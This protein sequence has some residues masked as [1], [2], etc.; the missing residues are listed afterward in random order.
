VSSVARQHRC[1]FL[2]VLFVALCASSL[3]GCSDLAGRVPTAPPPDTA[4][5]LAAPE[6]GGRLVYG[7]EVDPTGLDPTRNSWDHAGIQVAN[8]LYDPLAAYDAGGRTRPYL[9]ES[10]APNPS[11]TSWVLTLRPGVTFENGEP[12]DADALL[13]F[14][15]ALRT[16]TVVGP[17][18]QLLSGARKVDGRTIQLST[19]RP[20]ASLPAL[21]AGQGGYLVSTRTVVDLGEHSYPMGTGPFL[22]RRWETGKR[23][24]LVRNPRYWRAGLPYLDAVDFVV[25]DDGTARLDKI[26]RGEID[27]TAVTSDRDIAALGRMLDDQDRASPLTLAEV[28]DAAE[29]TAVVFNTGRPPLDDVR[30]RQ[31]IGHATDLR[32]IAEQNRWPADR[33]AQ[34]PFDPSSP[35][36]APA[37]Y[38]AHDTAQARALVGAYLDDTRLRYG[39][40]GIAFTLVVPDGWDGLA[41]QLVAQWAEAGIYATPAYTDAKQD[42][43]QAVTGDFD[44]EILSYFAAPDPDVLWHFFVAD[45]VP[46]T[47]GGASL[48]LARFRDADITSGMNKGRADQDDGARRRAYTQ[49][50]E[51]MARQLPYLWLKREQWQIATAARV[52]DARNTTLPDGSP[53][54]PFVT[55]THRLTETWIIR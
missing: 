26:G 23:L 41:S 33:I 12:L 40:H 53:A 34:G 14:V 39:P 10:F 54:L 20:W 27:A 32:A 7:L 46:G 16:S 35:Y 36:F 3:A 4:I 9:L 30:V 13:R 51:A 37:P 21:M 44:A 6:Q 2:S 49:V 11:F 47:P 8:A 45:T 29:K 31:A 17:A 52:R 19:S 24:E 15:S 50:Q 1:L 38:P 48:N 28:A 22:L 42:V 5:A 43:H 25:I 18:A 55:G